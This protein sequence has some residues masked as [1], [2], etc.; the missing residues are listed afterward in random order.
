M[1]NRSPLISVC[2]PVYNAE[3]YVSEAIESVLSQTFKD[4][5][6]LILDDGSTDGSLAI[7][8][9]YAERDP[10][11]RMTSRPNKG[12]A[13]TLNELMDQARGEFVARMDADD[14]SLPER[15]ER[16]ADYLR[17]H[18]DCVIVGC[19][20]LVIDSDGDPICVWFKDSGHETLDA[21][22]LLGNRGTSLCHPSVMMRRQP[23]LEVGRYCEH[24]RIGEDL[25]LFL[26]LSERGRLANLPEALLKYRTHATNFTRT[27]DREAFEDLVQI[28]NDARQRR[29]LPPEPLLF[30]LPPPAKTEVADSHELWAWQALE[31]GNVDTARKHARK[32]L[33]VAPFSMNAWKL[34]YC[35][36]R[37]H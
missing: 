23:V 14:V 20:A 4:F 26:K 31:G 28:V 5:E 25:D 30:P 21:Q 8:K 15:L 9:G 3:R 1:T 13:P 7:L 12:L 32:S 19:H 6:F 10:R 35:A 22:N 17:K 27:R 36:L 34:F 11:I 29:G 24:F 33:I 18:L 2:M 16:Q 37:G